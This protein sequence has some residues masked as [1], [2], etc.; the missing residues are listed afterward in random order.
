MFSVSGTDVTISRGDTG[1]LTITLTG[2]VP[3]DNTVALI[4]VRKDVNK[5][6]FEWEKHLAVNDGTI[7]VPLSSEDTDLPWHDYCWDLRLL[8]ENGDIFTPFPP[9]LFRVCE[10][11]GDV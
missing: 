4:T 2:D 7:V 1:T 10:V 5:T 11:V 9:A 6:D 3:A 8:Y